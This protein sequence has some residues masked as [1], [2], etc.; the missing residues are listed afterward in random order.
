M[1]VSIIKGIALIIIVIMSPINGNCNEYKGVIGG[2]GGEFSLGQ[3]TW[4]YENGHFIVYGGQDGILYYLIFSDADWGS[5]QAFDYAPNPSDPTGRV[6]IETKERSVSYP[7]KK[8]E[9]LVVFVSINREICHDFIVISSKEWKNF[10]QQYANSQSNE[11]Y[12]T[13][14]K[15]FRAKTTR[16]KSARD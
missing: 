12:Y 15:H 4:R 8:N 1:N 16:C 13:I 6:T 3:S 9:L 7:F 5:F 10:M 2:E 14:K 11:D